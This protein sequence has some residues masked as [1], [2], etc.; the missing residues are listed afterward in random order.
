MQQ[1]ATSELKKAQEISQK[2]QEDKE[3]WQRRVSIELAA[4][5]EAK[6]LKRLQILEQKKMK[7]RQRLA[8]QVDF[9]A[10]ICPSYIPGHTYV[11][12]IYTIH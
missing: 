7:V 12:Y 11:L 3:N 6:E 1:Q 9:S 4:D 10:M 2:A 5:L 8:A